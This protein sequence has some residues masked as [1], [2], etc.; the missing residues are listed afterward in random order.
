MRLALGI[1]YLGT[2]FHGWQRQPGE[3]SVQETLETAVSTVADHP[4]RVTCAGRTDAG[5]HALGQVIHFDTDGRRPARAWTMGVNSNLPADVSVSWVSRVGE[6]FHARFSAR[7]RTYRYVIHNS[8]LRS[9]L[10]AERAWWCRRELDLAAMRSAVAHLM[11][12]HDFSAFRATA[13]QAENPVRRVTDSSVFRCGRLVCL[14]LTANAFLH[15]MVRN[16]A[17]TLVRVGSGEADPG[18]VAEIL[19]QRDRRLAG[20]TAP[21]AGLY[22]LGVDYGELLQVP[23]ADYGG[24]PGGALRGPFAL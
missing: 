24:I 7:S 9:A 21:A 13:C 15:H 18:W 10:L 11:G 8:P 1:E 17:G 14:Q 20:M 5:V 2:A 22:F 4:V 6:D 16:V 19:E 12:E 3:R 23:Q